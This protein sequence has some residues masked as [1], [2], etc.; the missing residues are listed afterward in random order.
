M[1]TFK[2]LPLSNFHI[3]N[4]VSLTIVTKLYIM[5]PELTYLI[6]GRLCCLTTF[7]HFPIPDPPPL[8]IISLFSVHTFLIATPILLILHKSLKFVFLL[9][10]FKIKME[11]SALLYERLSELQEM[12]T[13]LS[14]LLYKETFVKELEVSYKAQCKKYG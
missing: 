7:T 12:A 2:I 5:S 10:V 6:T 14:E 11:R 13:N 8:P 3:H 9:E 4:T 1:W